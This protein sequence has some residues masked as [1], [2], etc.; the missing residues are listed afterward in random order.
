MFTFLVR[1]L[2]SAAA[3][4]LASTFVFFM[5]VDFATDPLEDLRTSSQINRDQL[6]EQRTRLLNLDTPPV[7]R[8]LIWLRGL[9][10]FLWGDGT[11]G[12]SW[13]TN[14]EVTDLLAGAVGVTLRLV[15]VATFLAMI[16]GIT[17]GIASALRQYTGFD[18]SI[19]FA[20]FLLYSLPT[21]WIAVLLK[22]WG[23]I[24]FNDFLRDPTIG[25]GGLIGISVVAGLVWSALVAG[26]LRRRLI[27]FAAAGAATAVTLWF[28]SSTGWFL[29]PSLGPV[30]IAVTGV[31]I[32]FA[33][34]VLS[35]GLR[36]RR[37]LYSALTVVGIGTALWYP[38][39]FVFPYATF[40]LIVG[41][42]LVSLGVAA[43]VGWAFGGPDRGQSM[44]TAGLTAVGVAVLIFADRVMQVWRIYSDYSDNRPIAT[45]GAATPGLNGDFWVET[46]DQ[47][48][49]L[50]LPTTSLLLISFASYTR[51]AR[52]S[53]LEVLNQDYIR[54]ARAKGLTERTVVM[55][56]A[57]RNALIPLATII[58]LDIAAILSGA[59]ITERIFGWTGMGNLFITSLNGDDPYPV[60][61][62]FLVTGTVAVLANL[63]AD[64]VYA[65]LDP[66]IRVNA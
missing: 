5:L 27:T 10:G 48:T 22:Q 49:H 40:W 13:R 19:T 14:R 59:V 43:L 61:G 54:T 31:A 66:R 29:N 20:S 18:Y 9:L 44:R 17:V 65:G 64:L 58:P 11:M 28:V 32:A 53:L 37:A 6:M 62:F 3:V 30:L 15:V 33:V 38:L 4:L 46:L 7:L 1:R 55:R 16:T 36:N 26:D 23:A 52:G 35:T 47:Y 39:Q 56:H 50:I 41:L 57:F 63:V 2:A 8:Y 42:L 51:Y 34:T 25:T 24:G 60:M 45:L 21:F 12:E